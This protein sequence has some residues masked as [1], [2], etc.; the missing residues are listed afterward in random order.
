MFVSK[1]SSTCKLSL[2]VQKSLCEQKLYVVRAKVL[3]YVHFV[4]H[5][6]NV[7]FC[8][9]RMFLHVHDSFFRTVYF[10]TFSNLCELME[11]SIWIPRS[12]VRDRDYGELRHRNE[13]IAP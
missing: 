4:V 8:P 9:H 11:S 3:H 6:E 5:A 2:N 13:K 12:V 7:V 10:L 1:Q